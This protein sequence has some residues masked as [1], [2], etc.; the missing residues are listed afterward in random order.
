M[1][2]AEAGLKPVPEQR[3]I[4]IM[5]DQIEQPMRK[6]GRCHERCGGITLASAYGQAICE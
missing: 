5:D 1:V 6:Y 2:N 4:A 3:Q